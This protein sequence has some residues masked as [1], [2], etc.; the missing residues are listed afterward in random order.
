MFRADKPLG[1]I[2]SVVLDQFI[3]NLLFLICSMPVI[4]LG[5]AAIALYEQEYAIWEGRDHQLIRSYLRSLFRNFGKGLALLGIGV[6]ITAVGLGIWSSLIL[7]G[8]PAA[9]SAALVAGIVGGIFLWFLGLTG[10]YEQK[11]AITFRN[12]FTLAIQ[13]FPV[14]LALALL[15]LGYPALFLVMPEGLLSGYLFFLLFFYWAAAPWLS[16]GLLLKV[17]RSVDPEAS[18]E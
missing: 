2:L 15:N 6:L 16:A 10:R 7:V 12:A 9:F 17:L 1:R 11:T 14:T 8:L 4:T 5:A 3:L 18:A 13:K